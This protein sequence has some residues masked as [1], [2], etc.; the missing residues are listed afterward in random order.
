MHM[1]KIWCLFC[2]LFV[3]TTSFLAGADNVITVIG[4]NSLAT[5]PNGPPGSPRTYMFQPNSA[6]GTTWANAWT[7]ISFAVGNSG[8]VPD[9]ETGYGSIW[10]GSQW[11]TKTITT[12]GGVSMGDFNLAWDPVGGGGRFVVVG[13]ESNLSGNLN[14]WFGFL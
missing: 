1:L 6:A 7:E 4:Q 8:N 5:G 14:I 11:I 12:P 3:S 13:E 2:I 9:S 10:N